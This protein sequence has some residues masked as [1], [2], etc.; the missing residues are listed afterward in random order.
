MDPGLVSEVTWTLQGNTLPRSESLTTSRPLDVRRLWF[1]IPGRY[2]HLETSYLQGSRVDRLMSEGTFFETQAKNSNLLLDISAYAAGNDPLGRGDRRP[3]PMHL[4][5]KPKTFR[6]PCKAHLLGTLADSVLR[7][8]HRSR[9]CQSLF[10]T[11]R[12]VQR[13]V[14][15]NAGVISNRADSRIVKREAIGRAVSV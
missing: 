15:R 11:R 7:R 4:V 8:K 5:F 1:G 6:R 13:L 12:I 10:T 2:D 14:V 9:I 3:L